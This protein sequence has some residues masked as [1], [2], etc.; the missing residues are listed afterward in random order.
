MDSQESPPPPVPDATNYPLQVC[1]AW[2][3]HFS[4]AE[5]PGEI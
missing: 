2:A 4:P 3:M 1:R 5:S